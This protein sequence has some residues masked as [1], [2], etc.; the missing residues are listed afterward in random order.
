MDVKL[1]LDAL[2]QNAQPLGAALLALFT[3]SWILRSRVAKRVWTAIEES[4]FSNWQLGLLGA[5][6]IVLSAASGWTTW[7]GMR[8]FT[9]EPL[10]SGMITFGIQGVM[11]IVAWLIGESFATGMNTQSQ[12]SESRFVNPAVQSWLGAGVGGLL[13]IAGLILFMQ[14]SGQADV[15]QATTEDLAW[16]RAGD[17]FLLVGAGLLL[18][19]LVALYAASDLIR[20]YLQ[21]TRVIVRNSM[22]WVMFLACMATSVFFSFDSLFTSIFPQSERVRAAELRAQNQV[23]GIIADIEQTIASRQAEGSEVLFQ[24]QAWTDYDSQIEG[25]AQAAAASQGAIERYM[26]AKIEERRRAVNEQQE[27]MSSAQSGQAGLANRK[28][29]LTEEKGR[30]ATER[31]EFAS[32]YA[33]KKSEYDAKLRDVDAKRVEALAEDKGV[34]G[35]GKVGRGPVY[36]ERQ[37][38]L[39]LL[40]STVKIAEERL[41]DSQKRLT[42]VE[43]RL[44][45]IDRELAIIDGDLAKLKGEADTA[46]QRIALAEDTVK[47]D[48][49]PKLDPTR[50]LPAFAQARADFRAS[51]N[52]EKLSSIHRMCGDIFG[53]MS[54]TPETKSLLAGLDCDPK[55]ATDA[56]G[57]L[58][59]L[60]AGIKAFEQTCVG[61]DKL[62]ANKTADDLFGFARKCLVDTALPSKDTELLRTRINSI[63]L[64][65]DDKAHRFV[66]TWNAFQDG[67]RLAY[68]ALAIAIAIDS[69]IFM[70][71]LFGA[72]AVRSPLSDVPSMKSRSASQLEATI[73]AALGP[74]PYETAWLTLNALR[75][76]TNSDGFSA[77]AD[78]SAMER[79]SAD[80]VRMVLTA[81][82]DIGAVEALS[83]NPERYRVRSE[84]REY[85][86]SI[87]DKHFKT[88][89]NAKDRA[90]LD[91]LVTAALAPHPRE[92]AEIVLHTLEPIRETE[93]FTSMVTLSDIVQGYENRVVR[94]VMNAGSAVK[95]VAPDV[96]IDDRYYIRPALY[97]TLLTIR[98]TAPES[99]NY[100]FD[101]SR[102]E[103]AQNRPVIDGGAL[104]DARPELTRAD[105]AAELPKPAPALPRI[106][107]L[108]QDEKASLGAYYKNELLSA[109]G[110]SADIVEKRLQSNAAR[111]AMLE[112]WKTLVAHSKKNSLLGSVLREFQNEQDR[113]LSEVYTN[114]VNETS[115]DARKRSLLDA[116]EDQVREDLAFYMLFPEIN[117]IDYLIDEIE[118]AAQSDDGLQHGEQMLRDQLKYAREGLGQ[119]NLSNPRS[120]DEIRQRLAAG[121]QKDMPNFLNKYPGQQNDFSDDDA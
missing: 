88:D 18:V 98:A 42:G 108:T 6:G 8:N 44:T 63:E 68:L 65:R 71:G 20:P 5:T 70:S 41:K 104:R 55:I 83:L 109:I 77:M 80:R 53:A 24:T 29:S 37:A 58:F 60:Q 100:V 54:G 39:A 30:L 85:L 73:N 21:G 67:N 113:Q 81:G 103:G 22:L 97:E 79:S 91:Q 25:V 48:S 38:E 119:L 115:G 15:R 1:V 13:F 43:T 31:P 93:G 84:L 62:A 74:H 111:G 59:A 64:A 50:I 69:L 36:R 33:A 121:Y 102:F 34:E 23:A 57:P 92:H 14:W 11:L 3:L 66:V 95:A 90:R 9:G 116:V 2:A 61:G 32:D 117:L 76:V 86:S 4:V 78:L 114:L 40:Q 45:A 72:N 89:A 27:R 106:M 51:P 47:D 35:T 112:A 87:C 56:A 28:I 12:K 101:R 16:S 17:K 107:P 118:R 110:L 49:G 75:P 94:R 96:K 10:L 99:A 82:A 120:W 46:E 105:R 7:D 26:N 52:V 19:A